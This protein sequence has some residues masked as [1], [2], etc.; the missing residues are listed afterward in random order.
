MVYAYHLVWTA[1][2]WWLPNDP[3]G[4]MSRVIRC[5]VL[6]DLG[7]LHYGRKRVQPASSE[8]RKFFDRSRDALKFP[9]LEFSSAEIAAIGDAFAGVI[10]REGYTCYACAIM[11][12]HVH[13][14]IRKHRQQAE[15]MVVNLQAAS[16]L[17]LRELGLRGL[18]H[19]VWGGKGWRV[20]LDSP[21]DIWRTIPY[22]EKNPV[23]IGLPRQAWEFVTAYDGWP[24]SGRRV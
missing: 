21:D 8:L 3:R 15:Q 1:Y 16:H 4:S 17:R 11:P 13:L 18:E 23:K 10:H 2:G 7:A 24:V 5:D 22:I 19:P 20:F 9:V 12:D 6:G 14:I